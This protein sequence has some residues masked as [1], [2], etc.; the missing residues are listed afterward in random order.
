RNFG[1]HPFN[2][3]RGATRSA[4]RRA[5]TGAEL[6]SHRVRPREASAALAARGRCIRV[7]EMQG[8]LSFGAVEALLRDLMEDGSHAEFGL[9]D[10]ERVTDLGDAAGDLL[11]SLARRL[12]ETDRRLA[13]THWRSEYADR[14]DR[15][16]TAGQ[17]KAEPP[18]YLTFPDVDL[19][20]EWC[21]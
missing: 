18:H 8:D 15:A 14:L 2:V 12:A 4:I 1:L 10:L 6:T 9:L 19:A 21:E 13:F 3:A 16:R 7:Y 17:P 11:S 5:Y 20:L